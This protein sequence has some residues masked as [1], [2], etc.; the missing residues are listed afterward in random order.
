M[1]ETCNFKYE[2]HFLP[3]NINFSRIPKQGR[4]NSLN[5]GTYL[6]RWRW[7]N[8]VQLSWIAED[9]E[10]LTKLLPCF[11]TSSL[12]EV[13]LSL[14][15]CW[16]MDENLM[17]VNGWEYGCAFRWKMSYLNLYEKPRMQCISRKWQLKKVRRCGCLV[18]LENLMQSRLPWLSLLLQALQLRWT[19]Y[20]P[21]NAAK[22]LFIH[23]IL[24][25]FCCCCVCIKWSSSQSP[26]EVFL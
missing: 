4:C 18:G 3:S 1:T 13:W 17:K 14:Q 22:F 16:W 2:R 26:K 24:G 8:A 6:C 21:W 23:S 7:C 25:P 15:I 20:Q 11:S 5:T 9:S 12:L 10:L 19:T